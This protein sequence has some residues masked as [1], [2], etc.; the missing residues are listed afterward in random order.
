MLNE[1]FDFPE[2]VPDAERQEREFDENEHRRKVK[3]ALETTL[4]RGGL[5]MVKGLSIDDI[6][7]AY[8][9]EIEND[10]SIAGTAY[11]LY[12][13]F[14]RYATRTL[15]EGEARP[16]RTQYINEWAR[17]SK[18]Y[19]RLRKLAGQSFDWRQ[20]RQITEEQPKLAP[21]HGGI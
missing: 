2:Y 21:R 6:Y 1:K 19:D 16:S 12:N 4:W 17:F 10:P 7:D 9:T 18:L 11:G 13:A 8:C 15:V 5:R 14:T 3:F 20:V